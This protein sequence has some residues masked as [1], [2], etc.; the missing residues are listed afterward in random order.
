MEIGDKLQLAIEDLS[1][2]GNGIARNNDGYVFFVPFALPGEK[3]TG[4]VSRLKKNYGTVTLNAITQKSPERVLPPCKW[5][6]QC[7]GCQLQH[8]S[9]EHQLELKRKFV[10]SAL[11][12][13][14]RI[15]PRNE[16][17]DCVASPVI[18]N[19]RNKASFPVRKDQKEILTGF[20][21]KGSHEIVPV[22]TCLIN[23]KDI[24]DLYSQV[25]NSLEHTGLHAYSEHQHS[26]M[27]RHIIFRKGLNTSQ[28]LFSVVVKKTANRKQLKRLRTYANELKRLNSQLTGVTININSARGNVI[29]GRDTSVLEGRGWIHEKI[30]DLDFHYDTTAFFQVN[31]LQAEQL[32]SYVCQEA[33]PDQVHNVLELYSGVGVLTA[34]LA[35]KATKV[36]AVEEWPSSVDSLRKNLSLNSISN[37]TVIQGR[38]ED[39]TDRLRGEEHEVVVIDPPRS[40]CTEPVLDFMKEYLPFRIIYVSCNPATLARDIAT[41]CE[42]DVYYLD[43]VKTFD[44]FPQT[45]HVESVAT[46]VRSQ[47]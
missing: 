33:L 3:V 1:S 47:S 28:L 14:A 44:M 20:F 43:K 13:V 4:T 42:N 17:K 9:Y 40:G 23:D 15:L 27:L 5:Y 39:L 6:G 18:W 22:D 21:K 41:L 35:N 24:D 8:C 34:M 31:P 10:L 25:R 12:R 36:T 7:G 32:F 11:E 29:V 26:G 30:S 38:V 37:V 19:Y 16:I 46:L 45:V 2:D